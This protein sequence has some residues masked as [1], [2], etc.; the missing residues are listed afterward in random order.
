[1]SYQTILLHALTPTEQLILETLIASP[2]PMFGQKLVVASKGRIK[3]GT[4]YSTLY[5][6][7]TRGY[8]SSEV[9]KLI[10][11]E[12]GRP[13]R[14]YRV[15]ELGARVVRAYEAANKIMMGG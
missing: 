2:K 15:T 4:V 9:E 13:H 8:A 5:Q 3:R 14:L 6:L 10:V 7:E 11:P 12:A 1:M